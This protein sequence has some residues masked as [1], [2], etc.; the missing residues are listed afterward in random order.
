M[1]EKLEWYYIDASS[2]RLFHIGESVQA[3]QVLGQCAEGRN[4][5]ITREEGEIVQIQYDIEGDR[6]ILAITSCSLALTAA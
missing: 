6:I 5:L 1:N 3:G 2:T 4:L